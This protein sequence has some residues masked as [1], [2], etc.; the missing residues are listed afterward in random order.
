MNKPEK[1][2]IS[3]EAGHELV[4]KKPGMSQPL[5]LRFYN[6][7]KDHEKGK[8]PIGEALDRLEVPCD[9]WHIQLALSGNVEV[10]GPE[11]AI[12]L[13]DSM[14]RGR[15]IQ[16][17]AKIGWDRNPPKR[18]RKPAKPAENKTDAPAVNAGKDS[19]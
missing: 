4:P 7:P 18:K 8:P 17:E 12:R 13:V 11:E 10:V 15:R 1:M 19:K 3:C 2:L 14:K 5:H 16:Q 9:D 6:W